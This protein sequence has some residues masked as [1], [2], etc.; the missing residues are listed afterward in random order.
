MSGRC[1]FSL[2]MSLRMLQKEYIGNDIYGMPF[3]AVKSEMDF[4]PET[5]AEGKNTEQKS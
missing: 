4:L 5:W 1:H 2:T 3:K